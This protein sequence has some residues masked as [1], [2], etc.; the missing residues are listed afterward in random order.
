MTEFEPKFLDELVAHRKRWNIRY[1]PSQAYSQFLTRTDFYQVLDSWQEEQ[2]SRYREIDQFYD[3]LVGEYLA[4][5]WSLSELLTN[6]ETLKE[7]IHRLQLVF[8]TL[9]KF[10][11]YEEIEL[12]YLDIQQAL[13]FTPE[14]ELEV[15]KVENRVTLYPAGARLLDNEVVNQVLSWLDPHPNVLQAFEKALT[16]YAEGDTSR[17][18]N[19]LDELRFALEQLLKNVLTNSKSLENQKA[20][21]LTWLKARGAHQQTINMFQTLLFGPYSKYQN[22]AVKHGE[23]Y[24]ENDVEF[25]IYLTGTFMRLLLRLE[26][27]V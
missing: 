12:I 10:S 4:Q 9:E 22:D 3:F 7:F 14:I 27:K 18:R 11:A 5:E 26:Q 19:L 1:S 25:M 23:Q 2:A 24:A 20:P 15:V 17:Y 13:R 6:S 16:M 8:F 21:L